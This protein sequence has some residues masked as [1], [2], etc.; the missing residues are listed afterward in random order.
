MK[1]Q[2]MASAKKRRTPRKTKKPKPR[3]KIEYPPV[4]TKKWIPPDKRAKKPKPPPLYTKPEGITQKLKISSLKKIWHDYRIIGRT[5]ILLGNFSQTHKKYSFKTNGYQGACNCAIACIFARLHKMATWTRF[6]LDRI[7]DLGDALYLKTIQEPSGRCLVDVPPEKVYTS[8]FLG[9]D[10]ISINIDSQR[11]ITESVSFISE[12]KAKDSMLQ[13]LKKFFKLFPSGIFALLDRYLGIWIQ[14]EAYYMFDPTEHDENGDKWTGVPGY[15]FSLLCRCK[16]LEDLVNSIY[17]NIGA[18]ISSAKVQ[19]TGCTVQRI[20]RIKTSPPKTFEDIVPVEESPVPIIQEPVVDATSTLSVLESK[21]LNYLEEREDEDISM[22]IKL[23]ELAPDVT[24]DI[25]LSKRPSWLQDEINKMDMCKF[26]IPHRV[27]PEKVSFYTDVVPGKIGILRASTCQTDPS[28]SKYQGRQSMGNAISA[29][30][31]LRFY[32]S[33]VWVPKILNTILR[34]GDSLY[35]DAMITIPRTQSLKLS[36]FQRKTEY[37]GKMFSPVIEDYAVVGKLQS[38]EYDVLDL[39]PALEK[40]LVDNESCVILGPLKLAVWVEDKKFFMM[41]PNERDAFGRAI[42]EKTVY[43]SNMVHMDLLPGKACVMWFTSLHDLVDVYMNNVDK[44]QRSDTFYLSKVQIENYVDVPDPWYNFKGILQDVWILRGTISQNDKKFGNDSRNLQSP[45]TCLVVLAMKELQPL[46]EWSSATVDKVLDLGDQFYMESVEKLKEIGSFEDKMLMLTELNKKFKLSNMQALFE[47]EDCDITGKINPSYDEND[48]SLKKGVQIYFNDND[49]GI[50]TCRDISIAVWKKDNVFYYFDSH[51]RDEMGLATDFGMACILRT[52]FLDDLL[53]TLVAN[54]GPGK[55]SIY[56]INKITVTF[57]ET[58][59]G[60][61][62]R[63]PLKN[64]KRVNDRCSILRSLYSEISTKY[65]VNGGKQTIPMCLAA[66]AFNKLK[67]ASD[68]TKQDLDEILNKGDALYVQSMVELLAK[69][70]EPETEPKPEVKS[71]VDGS[72][73]AKSETKPSVEKSDVTGNVKSFF[74]E[75]KLEG[76]LNK[77][78][79]GS[80]TLDNV[81]NE[82]SFGLNKFKLEFEEVNQGSIEKDLKTTVESFLKTDE[83]DDSFNQAILES[84]PLSIALWRD[85]KAFY[86]FDPKPRDKIGNVIGMEDW[87][88]INVTKPKTKP[89]IKTDNIEKSATMPTGDEFDDKDVVTK[90]IDFEKF[91]EG[92]AAP[93][94]MKGQTEDEGEEEEEGEE[95]E[96]KYFP[97]AHKSSAYWREKEKSGR[98]YT[99][100]FTKLDDL[101]DHIYNNIAP[102]VGKKESFILKSVK[103]TNT[104]Q[105]KEK[106]EPWEDRNDV[107]SGDWYDFMEIEYGKWILRGTMNIFDELFP[108]QN[109]GKQIIPV[110]YAAL[111]IA[112]AFEIVCFNDFSVDSI[113]CYGDKIFTFVK[114]M[115]KKQLLADSRKKL[116]EDEIDWLIQH[117]D[118]ELSDIPKKICISKFLNEITVEPNVVVGEVNARNSENIL[119]VKRGVE[120]FFKTR[121]Y[122]ILQAKDLSVAIWRGRKMYYMCDALNRGPNGIISPNG[123]ACIT[124]YLDLEKLANTFLAN[125]S[126]YGSNTFYIH[127][128]NMVIDMCPRERE[129][130]V[131]IEPPKTVRPGGFQDVIPGKCILKGTISQDDPKFGKEPGVMSSPIAFIALT[132]TLLHKTNTWSKLMIDNIIEV[133]AD[134]YDESIDNLGYDFNPWE[135]KLDIYRVNNDYKIGVLKANCELRTT[136]QKGIIDSKEYSVLNLRRGIEKFFEENTHGILVTQPLTVAI[137]E[138]EREND[139]PLIYMFDP[140]SRGPT[141]MPNFTGA[142]CLVTFVNAELASDHIIGCIMEPE[143]KMGEFTIVPVEIV[144]GNMKTS[145]KVGKHP[146]KSDISVLPRCSKLVADEEMKAMRKIAEDTRKKKEAKRLQLIGR[147]GYSPM[148]GGNAI[149]RGYK[150]QNSKIYGEEQRNNQD[151]PNCISAVVMHHLLS[152]E[153]WSSKTIDQILDAGNQLYTDSY[154]AYGPKDKKLG[155]ENVLRKFFMGKLTIHVSI[156]K[157]IISDLFTFENLNR[158]LNIFFQ[159][160]Q[161]CIMSY[162]NQWVSIFFKGGLFYVF[163]PHERN[164]NGNILKKEE[165]GVAVVVRFE[166]INDLATKLI[167]NFFVDEEECDQQFTLWILSVEMR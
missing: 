76:D 129:P 150:S 126:R 12:E 22:K 89:P 123:T 103:I 37:E 49:S 100:W 50:I 117:E 16:E 13:S 71:E 110:C 75:S 14:E 134:L 130:K 9:K 69:E 8:F 19:I 18:N 44:P 62:Y 156:Y 56:N 165:N 67:P 133:G 99:M 79:D 164:I 148:T 122:G 47:I 159:Q 140:N 4:P 20:I 58:A 3:P 33:K 11:K 41:D 53:N 143:Q 107:Y 146:V 139:D 57:L 78:D 36:N 7:L 6:H 40:F 127:N 45:A 142:A 118:F 115:R 116:S 21:V 119:D 29:L 24:D 85:D 121:N 87:S 161:F 96:I 43:G 98:A 82:F 80:I 94:K 30:I 141:G 155:M 97:V 124:R 42:S 66:L 114:R 60:D 102:K 132:M 46:K 151:I 35:R 109:R 55:E 93:M 73:D 162:Y 54:L 39:F 90:V 153:F 166:N 145:K 10:K 86:V 88:I 152:I 160:E 65:D 2:N 34:Y 83:K 70:A 101:L 1:Q 158:I 48:I 15:G 52:T 138:E 51:S 136:D 137:W 17:K 106:I 23:Q 108:I 81:K 167:S 32:K 38:Q 63:P 74:T 91:T 105:L 125:I 157:P 104:P 95:K 31:M 77:L 92:E 111:L 59:D 131:I 135:E 27:M 149:L 5:A 120:E 72:G 144:V 25:S 84:K 113:L 154:I 128:V 61:L 163:D 147:K 28:F 26:P 68:W 112:H 64:Y